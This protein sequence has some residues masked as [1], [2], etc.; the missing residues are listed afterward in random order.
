MANVGSTTINFGAFP[1]SNEASVAVTDANILASS[2]TDAW[3]TAQ[4]SS[5]HTV[6]DHAY[7]AALIG[8][9]TGAPFAGVGFTIYAR[10]DVKLSGVFNLNWV[11][12]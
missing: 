7:A 4:S 11:W 5:N 1:G 12:V 6:N 10:S 2:I 8:I 9:S 3:I